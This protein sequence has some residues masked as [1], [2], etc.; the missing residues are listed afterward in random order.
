LIKEQEKQE[1]ILQKRLENRM[2]LQK[3]IESE[4]SILVQKT[5]ANEKIKNKIEDLSSQIQDKEQAI[6]LKK[7]SL[8]ELINQDLILKNSVKIEKIGKKTYNDI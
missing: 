5:L 4:K 6:S 7:S 1:D 2:R 3:N 8:N